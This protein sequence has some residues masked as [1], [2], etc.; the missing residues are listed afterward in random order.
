MRGAPEHLRSDNSPEFV[1]KEIQEW[2]ARALVQKS[3][4]GQRGEGWTRQAFLVQPP[5]ARTAFQP[6]HESPTSR[7][8]VTKVPLTGLH[9]LPLGAGRE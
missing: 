4:R 8:I 2:L 9:L 3:G 5:E 1:A 6:T 7:E